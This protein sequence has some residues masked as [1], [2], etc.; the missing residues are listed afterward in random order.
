MHGRFQARA[1]DS[2]GIYTANQKGDI[3]HCKITGQRRQVLVNPT[4]PNKI[5][6]IEKNKR[7]ED[8]ATPGYILNGSMQV[9]TDRSSSVNPLLI[10]HLRFRS[11]PSMNQIDHSTVC[12]FGNAFASA[13]V[14]CTSR[15]SVGVF[16]HRPTLGAPI[17]GAVD[18]RGRLPAT[19]KREERND[20][21]EV[22]LLREHGRVREVDIER[23][24]L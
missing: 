5:S 22:V 20:R 8:Q 7:Y 23:E 16:S 13:L 10:V 24:V 11:L 1:I 4:R 18:P 6:K 12:N 14:T 19:G 3:Q 17:R 9:S 21:R 2:F 15:A